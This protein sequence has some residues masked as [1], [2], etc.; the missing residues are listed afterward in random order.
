MLL[1]PQE[2]L[3]RL[4]LIPEEDATDTLRDCYQYL[5]RMLLMHEDCEGI[6]PAG[7]SEH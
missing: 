2:A 6:E 1:I 7:K 4:P 5:K 3:K